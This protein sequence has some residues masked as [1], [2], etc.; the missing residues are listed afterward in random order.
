MCNETID[1][2]I[3]TSTTTTHNEGDHSYHLR[4]TKMNQ[5][6]IHDSDNDYYDDI[7]KFLSNVDSATQNK[8]SI[9]KQEYYSTRRTPVLR[10]S[11][12][13]K[14]ILMHLR[15]AQ[16]KGEQPPEFDFIEMWSRSAR[17]SH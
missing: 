7:D 11:N 5:G 1:A 14:F 15:A 17:T 13:K 6:I 12:C 8:M 10:P 4:S 3:Q 16:D 2:N 9:I